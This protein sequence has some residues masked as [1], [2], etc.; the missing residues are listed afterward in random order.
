MGINGKVG[1]SVICVLLNALAVAFLVQTNASAAVQARSL[2]EKKAPHAAI[3]DTVRD[4]GDVFSGEE[5]EQVFPIANTGDAPLELAEKRLTQAAGYH[6]QRPA[7]ILAA[8]YRP[9]PT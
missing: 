3:A 9:A 7:A 8:F 2:T 6:G 1:A 5:L 4:F